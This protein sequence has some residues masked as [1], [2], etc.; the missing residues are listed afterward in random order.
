MNSKMTLAVTSLLLAG[1]LAVSYGCASSEES[2]GGSS[3]NS[4]TPGGGSTGAAG[5]TGAGGSTGGG[6]SAPPASGD[7][8]T[9]TSGKADG[10]FTGY[11][12]VAMGKDDTVTDPTCDTAKTPITKAAPCTTTTNWKDGGSKLCIS[13]KIPKVVGGDYTSNWGMQIGVN[14]VD[15]NAAV[16]SAMSK[17][18][19]V[20]FT[21]SGKP[22]NGSVRGLFHRNG[23]DP[24]KLNPFCTDSIKSGTAYPLT[25]FNRDC[26][27]P[28][29]DSYFKEADLPLIDM[30]GIQIPSSDTVEIDVQDVCL[31]KVEFGTN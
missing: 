28:K 14:A 19:T 31:E 2:G 16:G 30:I 29:E 9:F 23:D 13:G 4:S 27:T 26:W 22:T 17:Y 10:L 24:D 3:G 21:F 8:I 20:T 1:V 18:K 15:P 6:S 7:S 5:S 25:R 11:S 12:F